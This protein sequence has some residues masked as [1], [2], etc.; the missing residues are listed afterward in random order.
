MSPHQTG[1]WWA[2]IKLIVFPRCDCNCHRSALALSVVNFPNSA[3]RQID[4]WRQLCLPRG[5]WKPDLDILMYFPNRNCNFT[6][7][8]TYLYL[9]EEYMGAVRYPF[10][11]SW[12]HRYEIPVT[13][14]KSDSSSNVIFLTAVSGLILFGDRKVQFPSQAS[15]LNQFCLSDKIASD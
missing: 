15:N 9:S 14:G 11:G 2:I 7:F 8:M 4:I 3:L 6:Q 5:R 13:L 10:T 1:T 12:S